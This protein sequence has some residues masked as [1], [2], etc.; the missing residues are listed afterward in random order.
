M[1]RYIVYLDNGGTFTD[2]VIVRADGTFVSG[3]VVVLMASGKLL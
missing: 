3:K 2:A 1:E